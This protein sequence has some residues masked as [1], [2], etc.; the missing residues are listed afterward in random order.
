M[1][2]LGVILVRLWKIHLVVYWG[3]INGL[4]GLDT[5][6]FWHKVKMAGIWGAQRTEH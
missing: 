5:P 1:I 3:D 2:V 4:L 6:L